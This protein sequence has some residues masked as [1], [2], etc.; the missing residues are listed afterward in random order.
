MPQEQSRPTPSVLVVG[1]LRVAPNDRGRWLKEAE[2]VMRK[3]R[4]EPE[5]MGMEYTVA[6]DPIEP[7]RIILAERCPSEAAFRAHINAPHHS[8]FHERVKD[9]P[10]LEGPNYVR[11]FE[12]PRF[13]PG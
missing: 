9:I 13:E 6:A 12:G 11:C 1:Y 4:A 3:S 7:D 2:E 10:I 5:R 8:E